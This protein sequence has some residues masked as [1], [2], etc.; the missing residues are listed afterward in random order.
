MVKQLIY[1]H[2]H[3]DISLLSIAQRVTIAKNVG[4]RMKLEPHGVGLEQRRAAVP[5]GLSVS[6]TIQ[7]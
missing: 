5:K 6:S 1:F 4:E 3:L 7:A 2:W